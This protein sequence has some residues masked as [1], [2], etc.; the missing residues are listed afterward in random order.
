MTTEWRRSKKELQILLVY[1]YIRLDSMSLMPDELKQLC[2]IFYLIPIDWEKLKYSLHNKLKK[3]GFS[4]KFLKADVFDQS[5]RYQSKINLKSN[6]TNTLAEQLKTIQQYMLDRVTKAGIDG[7]RI[8]ELKTAIEKK[9]KYFHTKNFLSSQQDSFIDFISLCPGITRTYKDI[10]KLTVA[11]SYMIKVRMK[12][13]I[14][15]ILDMV[16]DK[17][18][19]KNN[20]E[21]VKL[22][23][24]RDKY[25]RICSINK[26]TIGERL[27]T[28]DD[29]MQRMKLLV[30]DLFTESEGHAL[31]YAISGSDSTMISNKMLG[32]YFS[33]LIDYLPNPI[34]PEVGTIFPKV[35]EFALSAVYK[36][37]TL[38]SDKNN[39]KDVS[40][41]NQSN[42]TGNSWTVGSPIEVYSCVEQKW[43]IGL[44][45]RVIV[46]GEN[47]WLE[48]RY[49]TYL[50][51]EIPSNSCDVRAIPK[52]YNNEYEFTKVHVDVL[53]AIWWEVDL[54]DTGYLDRLLIGFLFRVLN[55][56]K[57]LTEN[58]LDDI[59][60]CIDTKYRGAVTIEEFI[61]FMT[62]YVET[63]KQCEMQ[64]KIFKC[65]DQITNGKMSMANILRKEQQNELIAIYRSNFGKEMKIK[66]HTMT[67]K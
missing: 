9:F 42:Q 48:I 17:G 19:F 34:Q 35:I 1:G 39:M 44:I 41:I 13:C 36:G 6:L 47:E 32:I 45:T 65:I 50:V 24:Q 55:I 22:H 4:D 43:L 38:L 54:E 29:F 2:L 11:S 20:L 67:N 46:D 30:P 56:D 21:T 60:K 25:G 57:I 23:V 12:S 61:T 18:K 3:I 59:F 40:G 14:Q 66:S 5:E 26:L 52:R 63:V 7:L 58:E 33:S 51:K 37:E 8:D 15:F 53:S 10:Y 49:N 16:F 27:I 28:V 64:L 62:A 31:F